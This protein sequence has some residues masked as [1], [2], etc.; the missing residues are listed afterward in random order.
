LKALNEGMISIDQFLELNEKIGGFDIDA[1]YQPE[2]MA[3]DPEALRLAYATGR[4]LSGG[5]GLGAVPI[6]DYRTYQDLD[7]AGNVHQRYHTFSTRERLIKANGHADNRVMLTEDTRPGAFALNGHSAVWLEALD[8]QAQW[9]D[10]I[11]ADGAE[12]T[13]A[14]RVVRNKPKELVDACWTPTARPVK[15][16]EEQTYGGDGLCNRLYASFS[17][18]RIIA[19]APLAADIVKCQLRPV[20]L[21]DYKVGFNQEQQARL[22]RIFADGVCDW[23]RPGVGQVPLMDT[24]LTFG[25]SGLSDSSN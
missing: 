24:W 15:L 5:G 3:A 25:P 7:P 13:T 18:P 20:E 21:A 9:L 22:R 14:A 17:S 16:A 19:G 23:S 10:S 4:L 11:A 8:L 6:I 1:K 12:G 2:R